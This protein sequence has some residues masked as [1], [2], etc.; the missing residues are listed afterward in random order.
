[1]E[2]AKETLKTER[3][4]EYTP[5]VGP[6]NCGIPTTA[7]GE[8]REVRLCTA[9]DC[10]AWRFAEGSFW[11]MPEGKRYKTNMAPGH[12]DR[13]RWVKLGYCGIIGEPK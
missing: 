11:E 8:L 12:G 10:L 2:Y 7:P 9:T 3:E 4:A 5:C 6:V 13:G 1:M